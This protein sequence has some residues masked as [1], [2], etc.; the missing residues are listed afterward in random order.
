MGY[1]KNSARKAHGGVRLT[2]LDG[3]AVPSQQPRLP[4]ERVDH[5]VAE[6]EATF[7]YT[8]I[9]NEVLVGP[10]LN[11]AIWSV[12]ADDAC[13]ERLNGQTSRGHL[14]DANAANVRRKSLSNQLADVLAEQSSERRASVAGDSSMLAAAAGP[15]PIYAL[16]LA[17][18]D[19]LTDRAALLIARACPQLKQLNLE[20]AA[21][22]TDNGI[23]HI[24]VSCR[25]LQVLN[26][27]YIS[28]L[29]G[30]AVSM[31]GELR[32]PLREL[33]I[34]G[35]SHVPEWALLHVLE[36]CPQLEALDVSFCALV[37]DEALRSAGRLCPRLR[38]LKARGCRQV[39][40]S[41][42][43]AVA[44]GCGDLTTLDIARF[45]LQFKLNDIA[46]LALGD[47]CGVLQTVVLA[48]CEMVTD[49]GLN[50]LASGATALTH[51][52]LTDCA[53][54]TDLAMRT[55]GENLLQ[56]RHLCLRHCPRVS[57]VGLRHVARGCPELTYLDATGLFQLA[58]PQPTS[59]TRATQQQRSPARGTM[60]SV[61]MPGETIRIG[62]A[63]LTHHCPKLRHLD[64]TRCP[65]IG[66]GALQ[67]LASCADLAFLS[68]A[69]CQRVSSHGLGCVLR[70]NVALTALNASDCI[71][72][73]DSAFHAFRV[74]PDADALVQVMPSMC[75]TRLS[76]CRLRNCGQL[77][78][79]TLQ[80]LAT[81]PL[82]EL[83][84]SGCLRVTDMGL[85]ALM[86][87]K[88]VA[89][90][91][92]LWARDLPSISATGVSWLAERCPKMLL[93]DLTGC[94]DVRAFSIRSLADAWKFTVYSKREGFKGVWP[95]PRAEDRLFV[96]EYGDC[97]RAAVRIQSL[98]RA[99][100]ARREAAQRR[101][102][103]LILWVATRLQSVY[104]GRQARKYAVLRRMQQRRE[105][106]AARRI[107]SKYRQRKATSEVAR[108]RRQ[109]QIDAIDRAARRIQASW[110]RKRLNDR[111]R[112]RELI[113]QRERERLRNA[114][115]KIQRLWRGKK[116][117]ERTDVLR[118]ARLA[119]EREA[120]E[121]ANRMQNMFRARAARRELNKKREEQRQLEIAQERAAVLLQTHVRRRRAR[122]ELQRRRDY[123]RR[124]HNSARC[125][126][127]RWRRRKR[128]LVAQLLALT[129]QR[130]R[131]FDAA[132]HLQAAW[133]RRQG[134]QHA[135]MLRL[136]RDQ[137]RQIIID[138][139]LL[140]QRYWR[141]RLARR[142]AAAKKHA[143]L[144][145]I[146]TQ[147]RLEH[148]AATL[149]QAHF[150]GRKGRAQYQE[151]KLLK[152]KRWKEVCQ[153]ET[154][155]KFYYN[156]VTGE[157]RHRRPQ[158]MLDLLPK[159]LCDNCDVL[160]R[161]VAT[162]E[163]QDC[164][165][166]FCQKCWVNVHSGGRRKHHEF[167][168]LYDYYDRRVDYGESEFPSR[169]PS[170][171][172][173][174]EMD[175][176]FLRTYPHRMPAETSGSWQRYVDDV[177]GKEW[178]YHKETKEN[179]YIPPPEFG[180]TQ[181]W[182]KYMDESSGYYY[183]YNA[184]TKES[185]FT[186]PSTYHT[187]RNA[188]PP[189]AAMR[190]AQANVNG[191][192][193][194]YDAVSGAYYYYNSQTQETTYARPLTFI[195]PRPIEQ[196]VER[197]ANDWGKFYDQPQG[198]YYYYN[199]KTRESSLV[200][201]SEFATPRLAQG[202]TAAANLDQFFDET[203]G[204]VYFYDRQSTECKRGPLK[205]HESERGYR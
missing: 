76:T 37:T 40:D 103:K 51:L 114:A 73:T 188:P 64:L 139:A 101:E 26:L 52:D 14:S 134:R 160:A 22:M 5:R 78:D 122:K 158:D 179:T 77:S 123:E 141:G 74:P 192:E 110:R 12:V 47:K 34:A 113:N 124:L 162:V 48:G 133:K 163:C 6:L 170:E 49:V 112:V 23:R 46:L 75:A 137:Q 45:D 2:K 180:G 82:R 205:P 20:K 94:A 181:Q 81:L 191:W 125:I 136:V 53:K 68:V 143:A 59:P 144:N 89:T 10:E 148:R 172:Q 104:R 201:P 149:V 1:K 13:L 203:S 175:G 115:T 142:E 199:T 150:R 189:Q 93:L 98:F 145:V 195:T 8:T 156:K 196:P 27:S 42:V 176:W 71:K 184:V 140:V 84:I 3:A 92:Y 128:Q 69:G 193:K 173:Q 165:E 154:A 166:F 11:L 169:W 28:M 186:R 4:P 187:P 95:R 167:R 36:A 67:C 61:Q 97:W 151:M 25:Q 39:S 164:A 32:L 178:F 174:D 86:D 129:R 29:Q 91:R 56:L 18:A 88:A 30:V 96:E 121:A 107:Q 21:K 120:N 146:L 7:S 63:A 85:L 159:P 31:I 118:A 79:S 80:L 204:T 60:A 108:L 182:T 9:P 19:Q 117:R 38:Q 126:Q 17:G 44:N 109:R 161:A 198:V 157:V 35:C 24:L 99:R 200:R 152:K 190:Q 177:S 138:A 58:D 57:D 135:K 66:D 131:E 90:L 87:G 116:A 111:L 155:T 106:E 50:W 127:R 62:V 65:L 72:L 16:N 55:V 132:V 102:Q 119:R 105:H 43:V 83:D 70:H 130:K 197:G 194:Y 147:L 33:S 153:E 15:K 54:L 202:D 183:Y 100:V 168:A 185:T 41:G 171:V